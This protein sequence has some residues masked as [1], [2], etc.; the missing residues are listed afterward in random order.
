MINLKLLNPDEY[1]TEINS[2]GELNMELTIGIGKDMY[3]LKII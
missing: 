3:H 1:I 2:K